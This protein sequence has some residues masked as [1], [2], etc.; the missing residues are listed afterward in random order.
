MAFAFVNRKKLQKTSATVVGTVFIT[1]S[2]LGVIAFTIFNTYGYISI[3]TVRAAANEFG[4]TLCFYTETY[5]AAMSNEITPDI[6][7]SLAEISDSFVNSLPGTIVALAFV[8]AYIA[9]TM[10]LAISERLGENI[11]SRNQMTTDTVTS[12]LFVAAYLISFTTSSSGKTALAAVVANN[13][14][15][16][17][18]PCLVIIGIK[19]LK[20]MPLM[21]G[22]IGLLLS[23]A[24]FILIFLPSSSALRVLALTGAFFTVIESI[25]AWA[26]EHY[27]KGDKNE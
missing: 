13:F 24:V 7:I 14:A 27:S 6:R 9:Q 1:L 15:L 10:S 3:D 17:L 12:L 4:D 21:L 23:I 5:L 8:C 11:K 22:I 16:M 20:K 2:M 26:K 19:A 25:D 18:T